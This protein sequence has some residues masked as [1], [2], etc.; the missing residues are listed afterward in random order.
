[1][2]LLAGD[3]CPVFI[4]PQV[5]SLHPRLYVHVL[6][7]GYL[8]EPITRIGSSSLKAQPE[9]FYGRGALSQHRHSPEFCPGLS[10][11]RPWPIDTRAVAPTADANAAT[12]TNLE[13]QYV[14]YHA[15]A[16]RYPSNSDVAMC[17]D[18]LISSAEVTNNLGPSTSDL[19]P[20]RYSSSTSLCDHSP[21]RCA[22]CQTLTTSHEVGYPASHK[23]MPS[24]LTWYV[25]WAPSNLNYLGRQ[26]IAMDR[27]AASLQHY[28]HSGPFA[29]PG[30]DHDHERNRLNAPVL[31]GP[32]TQF[33]ELR[34]FLAVTPRS[35][36]KAPE[37][38]QCNKNPC[39]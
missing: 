3:T 28:R 2:Y 16:R 4:S 13:L 30:P 35:K 1:M 15:L 20:A 22:H 36:Y 10:W 19:R 14:V 8:F 9:E 5:K 21:F 27:P 32:A 39:P 31:E 24:S 37:Q 38:K 11:T 33:R 26:H 17:F 25:D 29:D 6:A 18:G 34:I 12:A 23:P 7:E